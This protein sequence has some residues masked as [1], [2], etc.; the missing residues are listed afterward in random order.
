MLFLKLR[1]RTAVYFSLNKQIQG[2]IFIKLLWSLATFLLDGKFYI[3]EGY[4][5]LS[6]TL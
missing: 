2:I 3:N 1:F 5:T 4:K 6:L